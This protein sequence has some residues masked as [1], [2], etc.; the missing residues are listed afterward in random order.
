MLSSASPGPL[1][2]QPKRR[3]KLDK[4]Y[5]DL[6]PD[7][8]SKW[9]DGFGDLPDHLPRFA[10]TLPFWLEGTEPPKPFRDLTKDMDA[11]DTTQTNEIKNK[12]ICKHM[13]VC[14][15]VCQYVYVCLHRCT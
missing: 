13:H 12:P 7:T 15:H 3:N 14:T 8:V 1:P 6:T 5:K 10:L 2:L 4:Y 9:V 11:E